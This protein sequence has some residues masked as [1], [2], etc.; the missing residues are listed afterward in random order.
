MFSSFKKRLHSSPIVDSNM[1]NLQ[2]RNE[3]NALKI[4]PTLRSKYIHYIRT[5][6]NFWKVQIPKDPKVKI[7]ITTVWSIPAVCKTD[8]WKLINQNQLIQSTVF[9][10]KNCKSVLMYFTLLHSRC[11]PNMNNI[12]FYLLILLMTS[13]HGVRWTGRS[14]F[15]TLLIAFRSSFSVIRSFFITYDGVRVVIFHKQK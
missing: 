11:R 9:T 15:S 1:H 3:F 2:K 10:W 14:P 7:C 5:G 4:I 6:Q 13:M 12:F 8:Y